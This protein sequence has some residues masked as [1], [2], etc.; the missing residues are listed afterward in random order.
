MDL[1]EP[2]KSLGKW[3]FGKGR[4]TSSVKIFEQQLANHLS[5]PEV[6]CL[7]HAR[8]CLYYALK[9][10][11]FKN[12]EEVLMTPINL[13]DMVNMIRIT[14]LRERFV[15]IK[16]S[17]YSIDLEDAK[18]K[19]TEKTKFL[20][21]T[22]LNGF[23]PD[24]LKIEAFA[25]EHNLILIQDTTQNFGAKF[26]RKP[27]ESFGDQAFFSLCDLKVLHTHMGGALV[28]NS[29][30]KKKKIKELT[31]IELTPLKFSYL[32]KFLIEDLVAT[33]ILN[34]TL[35]NFFVFPVLKFITF[36]IGSQ[37][38]QDLTNGKGV[39]FGK[40]V[41]LKGL[42]G[43]GGDVLTQAVP[44]EMLYQYSSLQAE[45]GLKRLSYLTRVE[46][47]RKYFANFCSRNLKI[48][49]ENKFS[50]IDQDHVYW[51]FP[52]FSKDWLSLQK[53]LMER[54]I[55]SARSNLPCLTNLKYLESKDQTPMAEEL[56]KSSLYIPLHFYLN[57]DEVE[58]IVEALN[59]YFMEET[60]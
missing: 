43:G 7:P 59:E 32:K 60:E 5:L 8:I 55:D 29:D 42:F 11:E 17:D 40:I 33:A 26:D 15:D 18:T 9:S 39:K 10:Y 46:K 51:K 34:R 53:F 19:L 52:I 28:T 48:P 38:I 16:R 50:G 12:G 14:G 35:F 4:E 22:H 21:V 31:S 44:T 58:I 54:G 30:E 27:L 23:V 6:L 36:Y 57:L 3:F 47:Q 24:M 2:I 20:F 56:V 41:F 1:F 45:I 25:K 37:N 13:P 49:S